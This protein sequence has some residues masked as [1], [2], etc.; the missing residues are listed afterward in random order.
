M[1]REVMEKTVDKVYLLPNN[2]LS[3]VSTKEC[4]IP[5]YISN[6]PGTQKE[7]KIIWEKQLNII[8]NKNNANIKYGKGW[9]DQ[10]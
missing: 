4:T 6:F 7:L 9:R 1:K 5:T 8:N 2:R 10:Q 3:Y